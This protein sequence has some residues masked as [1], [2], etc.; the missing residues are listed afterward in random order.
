MN[1]IFEVERELLTKQIPYSLFVKDRYIELESYKYG[2]IRII[3]TAFVNKFSVIRNNDVLVSLGTLKEVIDFVKKCVKP[4]EP[5]ECIKIGELEKA[6]D[7]QKKISEISD[8]MKDLLLYKNNDIDYIVDLT[9]GE[10]YIDSLPELYWRTEIKPSPLWN[11]KTV[12]VLKRASANNNITFMGLDHT[13]IYLYN[14]RDTCVEAYNKVGNSVGKLKL[15]RYGYRM[16]VLYSNNEG[17]YFVQIQSD[18]IYK[19]RMNGLVDKKPIKQYARNSYVNDYIIEEDNNKIIVRPYT[20]PS[21]SFVV[22]NIDGYNGYFD[23]DDI[24]IING[25]MVCQDPSG[26]YRGYNGHNRYYI[27]NVIST[28]SLILNSKYL[29]NGQKDRLIGILKKEED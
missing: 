11:R 25:W 10:N 16:P 28:N 26:H 18:S 12:N 21:D 14:F 6:T 9:S 17:T 23:Q 15:N 8:A 2:R 29:T 27:E 19:Y 7:T 5:V 13:N 1:T 24:Q 22:M 3:E 4:V 20:N